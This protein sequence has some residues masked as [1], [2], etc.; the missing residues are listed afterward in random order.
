[1]KRIRKIIPFLLI[2]AVVMAVQIG[3]TQSMLTARSPTVTNHINISGDGIKAAL[4]EPEWDGIIGYDDS[5]GSL[6][7]VYEYRDDGSGNAKP[8]YGY[9]NGSYN[10]PVYDPRSASVGIRPETDAQ[11][12]TVKY[13]IDSARNMIPGMSADK[14]P[15]IVNTSED[16]PVWAAVKITFVY[17]GAEG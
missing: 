8:V 17:A 4:I 13:G 6:L 2:A 10:S 3:A 7:P 14:D 16:K 11:N 1:M 9:E 12:Q 15:A 5:T